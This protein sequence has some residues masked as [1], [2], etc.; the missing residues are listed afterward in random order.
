MKNARNFKRLRCA[1]RRRGSGREPAR[2]VRLI[3]Q[4]KTLVTKPWI[5]CQQLARLVNIRF[6]FIGSDRIVLGDVYPDFLQVEQ[7]FIR[8][9]VALHLAARLLDHF[10]L[11]VAIF[12][13]T[14]SAECV[15]PVR[16]ESIPASILL[17]TSPLQTSSL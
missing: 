2:K 13:F 6:K 12:D 17:A 11:N 16:I 15:R 3:S 10:L 5:F 9:F 1:N 14:C 4:V 7:R 8:E